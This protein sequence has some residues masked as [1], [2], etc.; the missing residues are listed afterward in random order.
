MNLRNFAKIMFATTSPNFMH[1]QKNLPMNRTGR[2]S[3]KNAKRE[4]EAVLRDIKE[5]LYSHIYANSRVHA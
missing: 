5:G 1:G 4:E 2:F 3:K